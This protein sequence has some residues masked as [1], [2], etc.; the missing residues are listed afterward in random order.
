VSHLFFWAGTRRPILWNKFRNLTWFIAELYVYSLVVFQRR[1]MPF[2][3]YAHLSFICDTGLYIVYF[4]YGIKKNKSWYMCLIHNQS[5]F[6]SYANLLARSC[7]KR[8]LGL[9]VPESLCTYSREFRLLHKLSKSR[10]ETYE[11]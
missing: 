9:A 5:G 3:S 11:H 4:F 1:K 2:I 6:D 7:Y 8:A 10:I